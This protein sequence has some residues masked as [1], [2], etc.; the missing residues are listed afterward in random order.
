MPEMWKVRPV[1]VVSFKN[2]LH[3]AVTVIPCTTV[4]QKDAKFAFKLE[5]TI[6]GDVESWALCDKVSTV[7]VSRLIPDKDGIRRMPE[8]EFNGLL[9][10]L[11]SWLPKL[12]R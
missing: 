11:F 7:A 9:T 5:T 4:D 2:T 12:P 1:V 3:G 6:G 10:V 8:E